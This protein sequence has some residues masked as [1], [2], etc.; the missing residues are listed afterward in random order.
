MV[1]VE[2]SILIGSPR[3]KVF[4]VISAFEEYPKFLDEVTKA[5]IIKKS[6]K[7]STAQFTMNVMQEVSYTLKFSSDK[8]EKL[9]WN[10]VEGDK[11]LKDNRG[12]W[13]LKS[14]NTKRTE[15]T[16]HIDL[17]FSIWLPESMVSGLLSEHVEKMLAKV[18]SRVEE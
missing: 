13:G 16:Y 3:E 18:K 7:G 6:P 4:D 10:F 11:L 14:K 12:W 8:P 5:K 2:K 1:T 15:L 17:D 9:S